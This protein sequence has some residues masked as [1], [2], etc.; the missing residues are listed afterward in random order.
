MATVGSIVVNLVAK[1][2]AFRDGMAKATKSSTG[3][4][5]TMEKLSKNVLKFGA[6]AAT[7]AATGISLIVRS[8][9]KAIDSTA[10]MADVLGLTIQELQSYNFVAGLSGVETTALATA[11]KRMEKNISDANNGLSTAVRVFDALNIDLKQLQKLTPDKQFKLI[12]DGFKDIENQSE[13]ARVALDLFGRSGLG[14]IKVLDLGSGGITK[15]QN[16]AMRFGITITRDMAAKVE[17]AND[18]MLFFRSVLGGLAQ[19]ITVLVAPA[20]TRVTLKMVD[21]LESIKDTL[22]QLSKTVAKTF[23]MSTAFASAVLSISFLT[24]A[25]GFIVTSL[26]S[27]AK[28]QAVVGALMGPKA[29]AQIAAGILAAAGA[30]VA[31]DSLF[32][33]IESGASGASN[34]VSALTSNVDSLSTSMDAF[35]FSADSAMSSISGV[36]REFAAGLSKTKKYGSIVEGLQTQ[37]SEFGLEGEALVRRQLFN[38]GFE[39]DEVEFVAQL[40]RTLE[41]LDTKRKSALEGGGAESNIT[42]FNKNLVSFSAGDSATKK[43]PKGDPEQTRWLAVIAANTASPTAILGR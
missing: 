33:N 28:A 39:G 11:F 5:R 22:P 21:F 9:L 31:I 43:G 17:A 20:I 23:A 38:L 30:S 13:R 6:I 24:R 14:L 8:Q 10:K 2:A 36:S 3:F 1:T 37:I 40:A 4:S 16:I 29:W 34:Q 26:K 15:F 19:R 7:A 18:A 12:A 32:D 25:I 35:A 41:N 27:V 42:Q